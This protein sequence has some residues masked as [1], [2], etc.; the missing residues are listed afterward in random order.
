MTESVRAALATLQAERDRSWTPGQLALNA[1]Q[2]LDLV[3]SF[4]PHGAVKA[5]DTIPDFALDG[6]DGTIIR[7]DALIADG[8]AVLIFFR[9]AG[10]PACNIALPVYQRAL[11]PSLRDLGVP[12]VAV[13][14]QVPSLLADIQQRHA[15]DFTIASDRDNLLARQ[16]GIT[17]EPNSATRQAATTPLGDV[18]GTGTWELPFPTAVVIGRT[19][20]VEWADVTPDWMKRTEPD[21]ILEAVQSA[22]SGSDGGRPQARTLSR[23]G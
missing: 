8:P 11:W 14:P 19:A 1:G 21:A 4:D 16:L 18:T 17:F 7:R 12:L 15:F 5:G 6:I 13:S 3:E 9:F 2:R 22:I 10:C 23:S 20:V